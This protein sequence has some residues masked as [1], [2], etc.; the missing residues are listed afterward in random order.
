MN[1]AALLLVVKF[2]AGGLTGLAVH[3]SGHVATGALFGAH[4]GTER[5]SYAG[6]PFFAVTHQPVSREK[7]FIISSAGLW[8]QHA[9][10]E[11]ILS[12]RPNIRHESAPFLKG[13]L[14]FNTATSAVYATAAFG[15]LGP[16]QRDTL[17]MAV[18]LGQRGWP[19]PSIGAFILAPAALDVYRY[20]RPDQKWAVWASR[21]SKAVFMAL[22]LFAGRPVP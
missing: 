10:S 19:E 14:A 15:K 16:P 17:G 5:I 13:M 20:F 1:G 3:E 4:P 9:G 18:S 12:K 2:L 6:I 22:V 7:E 8:M 11:L 21:G